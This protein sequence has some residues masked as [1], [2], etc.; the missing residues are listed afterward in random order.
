MGMAPQMKYLYFLVIGWNEVPWDQII[1]NKNLSIS[2][3][4]SNSYKLHLKKIMHGQ[5]ANTSIF[6]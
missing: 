1:P 3:G 6:I 5:K 4:I 2:I